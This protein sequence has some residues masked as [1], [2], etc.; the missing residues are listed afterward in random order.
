[1]VVEKGEIR[2]G[3]REVVETKRKCLVVG[4]EE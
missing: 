1:M 4:V 2:I 3:E